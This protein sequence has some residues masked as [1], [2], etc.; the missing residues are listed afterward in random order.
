MRKRFLHDERGQMMLWIALALPILI[1]FT[2]MAVDMGL[3]YLTRANLSNAADA[4][5]LT[6]V[7]TVSYW[8]SQT[9]SQTQG[10]AKAQ[11]YAQE[12]FEG[13]FGSTAPTQTYTWCPGS[14]GC[15]ANTLS[16]TL[17]ATTKVNTTFMAFLPQWAQWTL[18]ATSQATRGNLVMSL[19]LDRSGS[20]SSDDGGTALQSAVP[21]F[22]EDFTQNV[23]NIAMVSFADNARVDVPMTTTFLT[24]I[25]T[26]VSGLN[27]TGGTFGGGAG[28]NTCTGACQQTDGPPLNLADYQNSTVTFPSGSQV[29]KVVV[30]FTDGLMNTLQDTFNCPA[31]TLLNYGGT[32]SGTAVY[33]FNPTS[34]TD[35]YGC[36]NGGG[37]DANGLPYTDAGTTC[38]G[39]N[40]GKKGDLITFPSQQYGTWEPLDRAHVTA[41]TQYRAIYTANTIRGE[42]PVPTY[43]YV[44]GLGSGINNACTEAFLA[45][46]ANDPNGPTNYSCPSAPAVY[47]A[48]LVDGAFYPVLDCPS[49]TCT[50]ELNAAFQSIAYRILLRLSK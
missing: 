40:N 34:A 30:Y 32:D 2:A 35:V 12:M 18:G 27:F 13:N 4:G 36:Y 9:G 1:L 11:T 29:E 42:S 3:I 26:A 45:T 23:D 49:P 7:K 17:Y 6:G 31:S 14:S 39:T 38:N 46:I 48:N 20:M 16:L 19:V 21:A 28:T 41:E 15:P 33:S 5:V 37:C 8:T 22:V 10:Q 25:K 24:P 43:V 44:I 47:N 50:E